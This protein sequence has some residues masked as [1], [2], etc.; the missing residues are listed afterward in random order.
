MIVLDTNVV[1]EIVKARPHPSVVTWWK[2]HDA[3][4]FYIT[5]ITVAELLQGVNNS[6][7]G[8]KSDELAETVLEAID[9]FGVRILEFD[10]IA[11]TECANLRSTRA[12]EG[13]PISVPD[14]M[15]AATAIAAEADAI[16]TRDKDFADVGL[17]VLDPWS[18]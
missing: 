11:A 6:P 10:M 1:S 17:P 8:R 9:F 15:I 7:E 18:V 5:T 14:A 16:A 12:G 3:K 4:E 2:S 13:R